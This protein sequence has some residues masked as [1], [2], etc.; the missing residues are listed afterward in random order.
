M[1]PEIDEKDQS[2]IDVINVAWTKN[3]T[4]IRF[5]EVNKELKDIPLATLRSRILKL[6]R[7]KKIDVWRELNVLR[8]YPAG[9]MPVKQGMQQQTQ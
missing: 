6:E 8:C 4:G 7:L 1:K 5:Y 2:I 9:K 3:P